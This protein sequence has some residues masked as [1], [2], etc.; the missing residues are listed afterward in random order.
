MAKA[1]QLLTRTP[2]RR[3]LLWDSGSGRTAH[4]HASSSRSS[5]NSSAAFPPPRV[6]NRRGVVV[7]RESIIA[8]LLLQQA[9]PEQNQKQD[10][11]FT[12]EKKD[13]YSLFGGKAF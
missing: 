11:G 9:D 12:E 10:E 4:A 6:R 13:R 7:D 5:H 3:A 2:L 1:L 8:S